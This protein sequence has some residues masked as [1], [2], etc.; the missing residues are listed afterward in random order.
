MPEQLQLEFNDQFKE[1]ERPEIIVD[2]LTQE[3]IE[4]PNSLFNLTLTK[5]PKQ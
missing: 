1:G 5:Y 4:D 3:L 2:E